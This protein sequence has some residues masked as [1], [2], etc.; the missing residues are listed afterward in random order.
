M[1]IDIEE[2]TGGLFLCASV[3]SDDG[4]SRIALPDIHTLRQI[5]EYTEKFGSE[6][7]E[8][9]EDTIIPGGI[10]LE[11]ADGIKISFPYSA[12]LRRMKKS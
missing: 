6:F 10:T 11:C 3:V 8:I 9:A 5:A 12:L 7:E 1:K 2:A 4:K